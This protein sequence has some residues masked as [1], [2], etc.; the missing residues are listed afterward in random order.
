MLEDLQ[1]GR[2]THLTFGRD[3]PRQFVYIDDAASAL[4]AAFDRSGLSQQVYTITGGEYVTLG[5]LGDIVLRLFPK[6]EIQLGPG[7][8]PEDDLQ[9]A[10]DISAAERDI[11]YRPSIQLQ[12]GVRRYADW[13]VGEHSEQVPA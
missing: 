5:E 11:G 10:F 6:A 8:A 4:V 3:F 9:E 7:P 2:P 1:C 13:L 12:E